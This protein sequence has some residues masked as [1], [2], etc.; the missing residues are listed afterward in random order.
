MADLV[1]VAMN[2]LFQRKENLNGTHS[3][4]LS[5]T[6]LMQARV[7]CLELLTDIIIEKKLGAKAYV[8]EAYDEAMQVMPSTHTYHALVHLS[9]GAGVGCLVSRYD[10]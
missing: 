7:K 4:D 1:V 2:G 6:D 3:T 5:P 9:A 8:N 10:S